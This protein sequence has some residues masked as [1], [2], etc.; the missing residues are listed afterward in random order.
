M[1]PADRHP[2]GGVFGQPGGLGVEGFL[3]WRG[4]PQRQRLEAGCL[5]TRRLVIN[6]RK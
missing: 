3:D 1:A 2:A 5:A 6:R 4:G